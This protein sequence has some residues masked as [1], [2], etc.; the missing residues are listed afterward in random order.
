[1]K[2]V[3]VD[4]TFEIRARFQYLEAGN[5]Y[6]YDPDTLGTGVMKDRGVTVTRAVAFKTGDGSEVLTFVTRDGTGN[7]E[8]TIESF[9]GIIQDRTYTSS[10]EISEFHNG[11]S[12]V[13]TTKN[14]RKFGCYL[15]VL[16]CIPDDMVVV[17]LLGTPTDDKTDDW[18]EADGTPLNVPTN[19]DGLLFGEASTY[20]QEN[21]CEKDKDNTFFDGVYGQSG[22][23]LENYNNFE[24][25]NDCGTPVDT[26]EIEELFKNASQ[27]VVNGC[28][29]DVECIIETEAGGED[30]ATALV[31]VNEEFETIVEEYNAAGAKTAPPT[32]QAVVP[33]SDDVS[34]S[35]VDT[36]SDDDVSSSTDSSAVYGDPH[37][38]TWAG[39]NY[40]YHGICDLVMLS[41]PEFNGGLGMDIHLRAKKTKQWSYISTAVV[42]IGRDTFEV[43][44]KKDGNTQLLNMVEVKNKEWDQN[45]VNIGR[46]PI[47]Y[48]PHFSNQREYV[49]DLGKKEYIHLKTWKDMVRVD[50]VVNHE[51]NTFGGSLGLMGSYPEGIMLGR[52]GKA[53]IPEFNNFGQEWQVL[54][55]EPNNFHVVE[56]PQHPSKCVI[57]SKSAMRRR[58]A[59][60]IISRQEAEIACAKIGVDEFDLCVFDVMA[61]GDTDSAG[62]Y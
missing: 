13:I 60:S 46:F 19:R 14:A 6:N 27:E 54:S 23:N 53:I 47:S 55:S 28:N 40:D 62:A 39:L 7:Q 59:Q 9:V 41:H 30:A 4:S 11:A 20:C 8:C 56:G 51:T 1:V 34:S 49:I 25:Y 37:F 10:D 31:E 38:K 52:N 5:Q 21:W 12:I 42:R 35:S 18:M 15:N 16:V 48:T 22:T 61:I 24:Y 32:E 43:A 33:S 50:I 58:M 57:P 29:N 17:G 2:D 3:A 45:S 36:P 26:T 44:G